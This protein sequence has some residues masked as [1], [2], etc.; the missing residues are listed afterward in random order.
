MFEAFQIQT[1]IDGLGR[2][3][4]ALS[5]WD[6]HLIASLGDGGLLILKPQRSPDEGGDAAKAWQVMSAQPLI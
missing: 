1:V 4:V 3:I 2:R 6:E 5:A